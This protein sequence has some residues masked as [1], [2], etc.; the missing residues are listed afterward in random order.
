MKSKLMK[1]TA[2]FLALF[3]IVY[4]GYQAWTVFYNPYKTEI[5]VNYSVNESLHVSG[6]AVRTETI[7]EDQYDG[8]VSYIHEDAA[9][10]NRNKP[11]AYAHASSDTVNKMARA[12]ELEKD[13][14]L[15]EEASSGVSQLYGSSEFINDQ[16]GNSV[17]EYSSKILNGN[18][19]EFS[20]VKDSLLL[21]INKKT[22]ITGEP[23]K[24]ENRMAILKAEYDELQNEIAAD[25]AKTVLAP[26]SGYFISSVDGFENIINKE[27]LFEKTV[28]EI[29]EIIYLDVVTAE[30]RVGKI[31]DNYKWYYVVS[32]SQ[33]DAERFVTGRNVTV[34]FDGIN[35]S[36]SFEIYEKIEDDSSENVIVV[37]LC[38]TYTAEVAA[39][40]QVNADIIFS[41]VNGLR[42][43]TE[44]IRFNENQEMGVFILDRSEVKFRA[45]EVIYTGSN[46]VL[47]R[48]N[49]GN[50][51]SLQLFDEV[52]VGGNELY[53]GKVVD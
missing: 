39:L 25:E 10:V 53:V 14:S 9:K 43:S 42:I 37:L 44:S 47:V 18:Y 3:L 50:K 45:I 46:Y 15:L 16:I 34:N 48:L 11:I 6:L 8:S 12:A 17:M 1:V 51:N 35:D 30:Q 4:A 26:K 28:A 40:R 41:T 31:A 23:N 29:E 24:F 20:G 7:I 2:L 49:Q 52:F 19:S 38:K 13:I 27:N 22:S 5:A 21:A 33:E 32:V 36:L